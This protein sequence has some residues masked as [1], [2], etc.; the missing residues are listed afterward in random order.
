MRYPP[1]LLDEIRARLSVSDVV[2]RT[3]ALKRKGR[4]FAGLS[5]FKSEKTASF[6]VNDQKGFYHCFAS[7]EHGDIFTFLMKTEGLSFP[8]AVERLAAEAGVELPKRQA[9]DPAR[10]NERDR[11]LA[12]HEATARF[13]ARAL[14]GPAA[15]EARAYLERRGLSR[16]TV[17]A[18]DIG[19]APPSRTALSEHLRTEGFTPAELAKSGLQIAGDDIPAPYDRFRNRIMFPIADARGRIVA[20]GGRALDRGQPAKYLNSPETP[21]FHKGHLLF[22]AHR[23][24][25]PAHD[26]GE[27]LV[28]EGY[29][30]VIALAQAGFTYA[31]A[32]LGTA[33]TP[34]QV[35]MLWRLCPEPTLCFDGDEAGRRA[36]WRA[37]DT[38]LPLLKAGHS[39]H[40]AFMP[41][42]MDPDDLIRSEGAD[43]M[44]AVMDRRQPLL[45]TLWQR[46]WAAGHWSTPERRAKLE[47]SLRNCVRAIQDPAVRGHY[48]RDIAARL[49]QAWEV[50]TPR[51][52]ARPQDRGRFATLAGKTFRRGPGKRGRSGGA[53]PPPIAFQ[54]HTAS[55]RQSSLVAPGNA[56]HAYREALLLRTLVN[57]PWLIEEIAEELADLKLHSPELARLRDALL[58]A[59][60]DDKN[61]DTTTLRNHL[62]SSGF[63]PHLDRIERM[64]THKCD[65]FAEPDADRVDV[66]RGWRHTLALHHQQALRDQLAEAEREFHLSGDEQ[67]MGRILE[68]Q[69]LLSTALPREAL[70]D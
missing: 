68:L 63:A 60:A 1:H 33:L 29:M 65:A 69:R 56:S 5:P 44:R 42:G 6:F 12:V 9:T 62:Q 14:R 22:N 26:A 40:F 7:G 17:Q 38:A 61:L 53:S 67:A 23:A 66:D 46:E 10:E 51:A 57:H 8:E 31:V 55:L 54:G 59:L 50:V 21:I 4:E 16:D 3:V 28:V 27:L 47:N 48:G 36:A 13:F 2:G 24:R 39:L 34:E 30:D 11:L 15:R 52:A 32:P 45:E 25:Q 19:F 64:A 43:A 18:F 49:Q 70:F 20:F 35:T 37:I 58:G 41:K